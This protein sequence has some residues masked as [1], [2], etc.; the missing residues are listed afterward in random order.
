MSSNETLIPIPGRLHSVAVEG[1]VVGANEV[2]DDTNYDV[3]KKQ[4]EINADTALEIENIKAKD[5]N[6][7]SLIPSQATTNNQLADK[8]FVNSS[9]ATATATFI[10][11]FNIVTDLGGTERSTHKQIQDLLDNSV[12]TAV[13]DNDY[14]FVL[15]P[16]SSSTPTEIARVERYKATRAI[17][18]GWRYEYTLNNSGF[19]AAQWAAIN[20]N[21]TAALTAKLQGINAEYLVE[22]PNVRTIVTLTQ[23]QYDA[24]TTKDVNTEY[25]IIE[26][27]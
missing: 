16:T 11:T 23:A 10:G 8:N 2:V 21:I 3:P 7:E 17:A 18:A 13:D 15:I 6:I 5:S 22:S 9:I 26:S 25:N 24:L 14:C 20:S 4:S 19:T 27:V 12:C 1:N